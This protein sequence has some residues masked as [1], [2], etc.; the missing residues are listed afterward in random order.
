MN[1][2]ELDEVRMVGINIGSSLD[3][4]ERDTIYCGPLKAANDDQIAWPI[5]PFPEGW[6]AV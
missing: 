2:I 1:E 4:A 5:I 6:N 3:L